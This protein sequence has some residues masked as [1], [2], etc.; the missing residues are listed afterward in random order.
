MSFLKGTFKEQVRLFLESSFQ[1]VREEHLPEACQNSY[2]RTGFLSK[3]GDSRAHRA[4]QMSP[5]MRVLHCHVCALFLSAPGPAHPPV[6][7]PKALTFYHRSY[8]K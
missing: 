1:T 2:V 6:P 7:S 4:L 3:L 5:D 8:F